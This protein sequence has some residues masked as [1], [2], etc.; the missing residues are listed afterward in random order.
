MK[1]K[2]DFVFENLVEI[3]KAHCKMLDG[4]IGEVCKRISNAWLVC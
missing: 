1:N 3:F 4:T 2:F